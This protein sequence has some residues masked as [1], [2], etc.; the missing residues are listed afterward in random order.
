M[1]KPIP[2]GVFIILLFLS[3]SL[4]FSQP[5]ST[6]FGKVADDLVRMKTYE[7]DPDAEA[8]VTYDYGQAFIPVGGNKW[9]I[10]YVFHRRVKILSEAGLSYADFEIPFYAKSGKESVFKIKGI[11]HNIDEKGKIIKIPLEKKGIYR[12][13][14]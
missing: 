12:N 5:K 10:E 14:P 4:A 11:T 8:V 7:K 1:Q 13:I 3:S 6:K 9:A 2:F